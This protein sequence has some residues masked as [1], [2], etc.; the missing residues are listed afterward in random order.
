MGKRAAIA[1]GMAV[2]AAWGIMLLW[3]GVEAFDIPIFSFLPVMAFAFL[4]P[5]LVLIL[6]IGRLAQRRFFDDV[7]ID[8]EPSPVGSHADIDRRVLQNTVEQLVL[9]LCVWPP[10]AY[11]LTGDGPGVL[12]ALGLGF[13]IARLLF[14]IGYHL[15]P[16]LRAFGFAATFY[17]TVM[18][19]LWAG[20]AFIRTLS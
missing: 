3:L 7:I 10:S 5:G 13:T 14:W 20:I 19:V 8:G 18:V 6:M 1:L 2:G 15:S 12:V 17:P 4:G 11:L 16:P 9:A